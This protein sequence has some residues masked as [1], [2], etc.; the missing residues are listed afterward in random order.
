MTGPGMVFTNGNM[1]TTVGNQV[2]IN[3]QKNTF[4]ER[5]ESTNIIDPKRSGNFIITAKRHLFDVNEESHRYT[6][7]CSRLSNYVSR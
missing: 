4:A 5:G 7:Q 6:M 1:L 2:K 3:I